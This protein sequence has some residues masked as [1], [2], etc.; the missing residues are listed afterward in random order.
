MNEARATAR[1]TCDI[2]ARAWASVAQMAMEQGCNRTEMLR[3]CISTELWRWREVA[4]AGAT[5][6]VIDKDG[7]QTRVRFPWDGR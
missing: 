4:Q 7:V 2:P 1:I 3:R 5:L 6:V